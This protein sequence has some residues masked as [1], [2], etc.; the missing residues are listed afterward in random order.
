MLK[1]YNEVSNGSYIDD[2]SSFIL[3]TGVTVCALHPGG[4]NSDIWR[5]YKFLEN[6]FLK[7]FVTLIAYLFLKDCKQGAQT[8]IYCSAAEELE[9]VS[10][11]YFSD[12]KVREGNKLAKDPGLA[13]KLWD[14]SERITGESWKY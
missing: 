3:G 9:G 5:N 7:P 2:S 13:K 1:D 4:V 14:V 6:P 10:G 12:C 11:L 8:S